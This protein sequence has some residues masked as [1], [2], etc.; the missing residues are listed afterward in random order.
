MKSAAF[1]FA[2]LF[3]ISLSLHAQ[4]TTADD[5]LPLRAKPNPWYITL[6]G[7]YYNTQDSETKTKR[8]TQMYDASAGLRLTR[9]FQF[10]LGV[11][12]NDFGPLQYISAYSEHLYYIAPNAKLK[13]FLHLKA[14]FGF[15]FQADTDT[16]DFI[17]GN[18]LQPGVGA[19]WRFGGKFALQVSGTY[20]YQAATVINSVE[21]EGANNPFVLRNTVNNYFQGY[22]GKVSLHF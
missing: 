18:M 11:G 7:G 21:F 8:E 19:E 6:S 3:G 4:D 9:F 2:I 1:L 14:G 10:G 22:G 12:Y 20:I 13:P 17:S 15:P 16:Q 5:D